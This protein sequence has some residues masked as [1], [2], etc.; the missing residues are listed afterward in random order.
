MES[1]DQRDAEPDHQSAHDE[2]ADDSPDKHA[3]L[4]FFRDLEV[5]EDEDENENIIDAERV[6][7]DVAG[8]E[9]ERCF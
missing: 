1:I 4:I 5:G 3:M 2:R 9:I 6:F 8:E 7:D